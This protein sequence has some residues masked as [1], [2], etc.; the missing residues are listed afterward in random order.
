MAIELIGHNWTGPSP[1]QENA[2][3]NNSNE[4]KEEVWG[5]YVILT[6]QKYK[7]IYEQEISA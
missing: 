4:D 6:K 2:N 7:T 5:G 3:T 1:Q